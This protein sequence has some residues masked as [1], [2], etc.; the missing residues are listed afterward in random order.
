MNNT[1]DLHEVNQ[2]KDQNFPL[3]M[4][5]VNRYG[6][7]P[8][9]R[10]YQDLHWHEELQFTLVTS[11]KIVIEVS[12]ECHEL[13]Q[14]EAV[15]INSGLMHVTT[16]ISED[17]EYVSFNF[18]DKLLSFFPG[19]RMEQEYVR[20]FTSDYS[21]PAIVFR[22]DEVWHQEII[23][24]LYAVEQLMRR[25]DCYGWEYQT[26][27]GILELWRIFIQNVRHQMVRQTGSY[28][29][30]Q[31][32]IQSLIGYVHENYMERITLETLAAAA[33]I[34]EGECCRCFRAMLHMTPMEYVKDY[35][36]SKSAELLRSSPYSVTEIAGMVGYNFTSHFIRHFRQ[37]MNSTPQ[38][39]RIRARS[40]A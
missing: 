7:E 33:H 14:G 18:P 35:R 34:S 10:G 6:M 21:V 15:F 37:K 1:Q 36:I 5:R 22:S 16:F 26:A 8:R 29:R 32:R 11:G 24:R 3:E 40:R 28:I 2:Y 25:Q 9:G 27:I 19:S 12:G 23:T 38:D 30:R 31:E 39:Y 20:P 17:G 4:Y 13:L